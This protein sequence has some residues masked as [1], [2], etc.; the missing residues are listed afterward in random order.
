MLG[1]NPH[2]ESI[3]AFNED[4]KIIKPAI[5]LLTKRIK[6]FGPFSADTMFL[7]K[8]RKKFDVIVGMYHDKF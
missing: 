3:H 5:K 8:N 1:L 4:D 2:C 6:L 7:K